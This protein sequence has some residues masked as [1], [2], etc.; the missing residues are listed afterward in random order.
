MDLNIHLNGRDSLMGSAHLKVHIAEEVLQALD[1]RQ[2]QV[3]VVGLARYQSAG[4]SG[5]HGLNG[6][7]CRH[8]RQ[9]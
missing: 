7:A 6:H 8:Q 2:D 1:I 4:N 9:G 5:Y 3:I